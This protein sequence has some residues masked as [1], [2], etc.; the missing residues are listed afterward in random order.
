M[1]L[2]GWA[3][4][5]FLDETGKHNTTAL[6]YSAWIQD[7]HDLSNL[8]ARILSCASANV[9]ANGGNVAFYCNKTADAL[10]DK[11]RG[12]TNNSERLSLYR[13]F[14]DVVV[15][16]DFPWVPMYST[17]ESAISATRVHGYQIHP[18][19]PFIATSIW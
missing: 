11:A 7:F 17:V 8:T 13:Q 18:V 2:K 16:Q 12:D 5:A 15:T 3:F 6:S 10:A 14:Q 4:K 9:T 19:W 1:K